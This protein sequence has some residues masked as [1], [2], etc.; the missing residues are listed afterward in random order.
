MFIYSIISFLV[1]F[2]AYISYFFIKAEIFAVIEH[3]LVLSL[4]YR[5]YIGQAIQ[6][7]DEI[8]DDSSSQSTDVE[9]LY[10]HCDSDINVEISSE[11][12]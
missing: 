6:S 3:L 10:E 11:M 9:Y 12:Y 5:I 7:N 4:K 1:S 8:S 2:F